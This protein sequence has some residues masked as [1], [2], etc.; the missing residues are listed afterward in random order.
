MG[1]VSS[2]G[3]SLS[4]ARGLLS[5]LW[6]QA[7]PGSLP[8]LPRSRPGAVVSFI[9]RVPCESALLC[10]CTS[11]LLRA[12]ASFITQLSQR[13]EHR[14]CSTSTAHGGA[15]SRSL[16]GC[17]APSPPGWAPTPGA[18]QQHPGRAVPGVLLHPRRGRDVLTPTQP[19][20]Y[21]RIHTYVPAPT[22]LRVP[23]PSPPR[24]LLGAGCCQGPLRLQA[25]GEGLGG[26]QEIPGAVSPRDRR[27][28]TGRSRAPL[29]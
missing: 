29:P 8:C 25:R 19:Y 23:P 11:Q 20:E 27:G 13:G 17:A 14:C 4:T 15:G 24:L 18:G 9:S 28:R 1:T 3:L 7:P 2:T 5:P 16:L 10:S 22:Q 6:A 21:G 12:A 26:S